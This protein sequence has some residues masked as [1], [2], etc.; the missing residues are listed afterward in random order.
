MLASITVTKTPASITASP[1]RLRYLVTTP[2]PYE[3]DPAAISRFMANS[4]LRACDSGDLVP[5]A[6]PSADVLQ[7]G[8][9]GFIGP[10]RAFMSDAVDPHVVELNVVPEAGKYL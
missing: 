1:M 8:T 10:R 5:K 3:S 7:S 6:E 2:G 9:R 4:D